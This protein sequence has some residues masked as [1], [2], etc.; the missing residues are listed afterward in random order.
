MYTLLLPFILIPFLLSSALADRHLNTG[1]CDDIS[2][3][4]R[5]A[6]RRG[7]LTKRQAKRL[8]GNCYDH[9]SSHEP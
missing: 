6:V 1:M 7:R 3:E 4:I 2:S 9:A 5:E 8:I